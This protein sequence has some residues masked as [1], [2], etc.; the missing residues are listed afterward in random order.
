MYRYHIDEEPEIIVYLQREFFF[1]IFIFLNQN[2][3]YRNTYT[4]LLLHTGGTR[5]NP[6]QTNPGQT[7][8]GQTNPGHDKPWTRQTPDTTNPG[9]EKPWTQ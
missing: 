2:L 3:I 9:H 8:P 1:I 6:G 5:T 7:N 4:R